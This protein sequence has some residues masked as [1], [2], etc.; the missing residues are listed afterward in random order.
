[1]CIINRLNII[2]NYIM[3]S[4]IVKIV[5]LHDR[6]VVENM[7]MCEINNNTNQSLQYHY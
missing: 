1:M 3:L 5:I 6:K 4:K 2:I 7:L